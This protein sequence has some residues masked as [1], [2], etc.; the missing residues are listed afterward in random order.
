MSGLFKVLTTPLN[1]FK[2]IDAVATV[3]ARKG[4][5]VVNANLKAFDLGLNG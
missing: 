3:F 4:E 2:T 1:V 5:S